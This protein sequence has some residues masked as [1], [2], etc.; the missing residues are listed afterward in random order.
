[1]NGTQC[2]RNL[3]VSAS[4]VDNHSVDNQKERGC[5]RQWTFYYRQNW[6]ELVIHLKKIW[7]KIEGD[8]NAEAI[9]K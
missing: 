1:M 6:K 3:F 4:S 8:E 5:E 9:C 7:A 2:H